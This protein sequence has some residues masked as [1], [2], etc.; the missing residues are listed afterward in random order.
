MKSTYVQALVRTQH[1][2]SR[3]DPEGGGK[4]PLTTHH[5]FHGEKVAFGIIG[6]LVLENRD[7][8]EITETIRFCADIGLPVRLA[9]LGLGEVSDA[10]LLRVGEAAMHPASVIYSVPRTLTARI[11]ADAIRTADAIASHLLA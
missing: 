9:E 5:F 10:E 1:R 8:H 4:T 7:P 6:L 3:R 11:I 2:Q